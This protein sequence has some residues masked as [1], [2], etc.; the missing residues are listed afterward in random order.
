ML[1]M[2]ICKVHG[3][4]AAGTLP[5]EFGT[6]GSWP[7]LDYLELSNNSLHGSL[8]EQFGQAGAWPMLGRLG[9]WMNDITGD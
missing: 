9:L 1:P 8:P 3:L 5:A 4:G 2:H 7:A 6:V